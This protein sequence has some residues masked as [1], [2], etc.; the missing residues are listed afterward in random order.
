LLLRIHAATIAH[1]KLRVQAFLD[2][3]DVVH[4]ANSE[5][6][7]STVP[8]D[9]GGNFEARMSTASL[10]TTSTTNIPNSLK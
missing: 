9:F 5:D 1:D 4:P 7:L 2:Y 8:T 3:L 6:I 10:L